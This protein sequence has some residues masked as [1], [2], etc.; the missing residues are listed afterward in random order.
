M[1]VGIQRMAAYVPQYALRMTEL[2]AARGVPAE[3][4]TRGLGVQEM[5]GTALCHLL[6]IPDAP[7]VTLWLLKRARELFYDVVGIVYIAQQTA[8]RRAPAMEPP[9]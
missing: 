8:L 7:A 2:A 3:K 6:G 1:T 5:G 9:A 4:M